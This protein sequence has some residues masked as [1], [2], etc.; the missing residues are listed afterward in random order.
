[1]EI[2]EKSSKG[3]KREYSCSVPSKD[4][5]DIIDGYI[6]TYSAEANLPGFRKGKVPAA[7]IKQRYLEEIKQRS[8]QDMLQKSYEKFLKERQEEGVKPASE[9]HI[10]D[11]DLKDDHSLQYTISLECLPKF[12]M[13]DFASLKVEAPVVDIDDKEIEEQLKDIA[14]HHKEYTK[15]DKAKA[16]K[17]DEVLTD[18]E[19]SVDGVKFA[20]GK[21]DNFPI[22]IGSNS[23]IPGF[24]DQLVGVK[25]GD[26]LTVKVTFPDDYPSSG[27]VKL[28]G[29]DGEFAVKVH[30]VRKGV[31]PEI[32]DELA[33][34]MQ[35]ENLEELRVSIKETMEAEFNNTARILMKKELFDKLE[36]LCKYELPES[37]VQSHFDS[38]WKEFEHRKKANPDYVDK[39]EE[40]LKKDYQKI[41]ERRVRLGILIMEL[42]HQEKIEP[43][44]DEIRQAIYDRARQFPGQEHKIVE[45]FRS[46]PK[47]IE[48]LKGPIVEE[49]T[50]DWIL[51]KVT[52]KEKKVTKKELFAMLEKDNIL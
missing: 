21:A 16:K 46:N 36:K 29:Q 12:D 19:G 18:I 22:R 48:E 42:A 23:L 2:T 4:M 52:K 14:E 30:E 38:L 32:D 10:D 9:P 8:M 13:P 45:Y 50:V 49:K 27:D 51:E 33:K 40:E 1:M 39:P 34:K 41:S 11:I 25:A 44:Q 3:L 35:K 15:D 28:A 17:G 5:N 47:A 20:A 6:K 43:A 7:V 31:L 26:K 24:E 37:M